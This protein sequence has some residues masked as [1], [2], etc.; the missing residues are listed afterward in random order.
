MTTPVWPTYAEIQFAGYAEQP[1]SAVI[2]T[3]MDDGP[4]KLRRTKSRVMVRRPITAHLRTLSAYQS[5]MTWFRAA[6]QANRGAA[7]FDWTDPVDG[8]TKLARIMGGQITEARPI[9]VGLQGWMV[10]M[11]LE[12]WD[13]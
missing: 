9:R 5:F 7:W 12:T 2:Q 1:E 10:A 11:T 3:E 6:D 13:A 8:V 4:A